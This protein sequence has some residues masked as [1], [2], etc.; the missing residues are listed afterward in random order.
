MKIFIFA[1]ALTFATASTVQAE[2]SNW[3]RD[4]YLHFRPLSSNNPQFLRAARNRIADNC[5]EKILDI[6]FNIQ[7]L[8]RAKKSYFTSVHKQY[9]NKVVRSC[10]EKL[11]RFD[12]KIALL[13]AP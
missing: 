11:K 5:D 2:D 10:S 4:L 7:V 12:E 8:E 1:F 9:L 6:Q 13:E 3:A